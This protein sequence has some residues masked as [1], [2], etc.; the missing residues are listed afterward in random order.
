MLA[1]NKSLWQNPKGLFNSL[2]LVFIHSNSFLRSIMEGKN[3]ANLFQNKRKRYRNNAIYMSR[4][5]KNHLP[6]RITAYLSCFAAS[7]NFVGANE[8]KHSILSHRNVCLLLLWFELESVH[9]ICWWKHAM[10]CATKWQI[11]S[12][13]QLFT[14]KIFPGKYWYA[15]PLE[16]E[17]YSLGAKPRDWSIW[18]NQLSAN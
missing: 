6:L 13:R 3:F 5:T 16:N 17:A 7:S 14:V 1:N 10:C 4:C 8:R 11:L 15:S 9:S 18:K 2:S 12:S